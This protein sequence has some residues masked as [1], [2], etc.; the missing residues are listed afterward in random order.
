MH[1]NFMIIR[2]LLAYFLA[3]II[4]V[5]KFR[6]PCIV[7]DEEDVIDFMLVGKT[8]VNFFGSSTY[9]HSYVYDK[10]FNDLTL[11]DQLRFGA[12]R[13]GTNRCEIIITNI[14]EGV[15]VS[16]ICT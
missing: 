7:T 16:L 5:W 2:F 6:V 13:S 14:F 4:C 10:K 12:F 1:V 9:R 11:L 8:T 15:N 3:L